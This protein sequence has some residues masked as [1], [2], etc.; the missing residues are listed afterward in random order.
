MGETGYVG[1]RLPSDV[2]IKQDA[3]L[4]ELRTAHGVM[5]REKSAGKEREGDCN[6]GVRK[7]AWSREEDVLL[8]ICIGKC[9]KS[10]RLRWFNYLSPN[11]K[12]GPFAPDEDDLIVRMHTLLG[13]RWSLI[14]GRMLGRTA[15]D[16]KNR[17]NSHLNK[18]ITVDRQR[19]KEAPPIPSVVV[20]KPQVHRPTVKTPYWFF[21]AHEAQRAEALADSFI[22]EQFCFS[23]WFDTK[24]IQGGGGGGELEASHQT[25]GGSILLPGRLLDSDG[26]REFLLQQ[27]TASIETELEWEKLLSDP[28]FWS[29]LDEKSAA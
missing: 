25:R 20:V 18:Q 15:N 26:R 19:E 11:I 29:S 3:W 10:C 8:R 21:K 13:N 2:H 6:P 16:I 28:D 24:G 7:R 12:R 4:A 22:E 23:S 9:R 5:S 14:A 1:A 27:T 17:W